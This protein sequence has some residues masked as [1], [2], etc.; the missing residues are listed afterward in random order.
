MKSLLYRFTTTAALLLGVAVFLPISAQEKGTILGI[1]Y[2]AGNGNPLPQTK[3]E[4]TGPEAL[5]LTTDTDGAYTAN[6]PAGT[7][8]IKFASEGKLPA[9]IDGLLVVAGEVADG[10]TVLVAAGEATQVEVTASIA[11]EVATAEVLLTERKLADTVQDSISGEEIK[12]GTANDAAG[13]LE[14]VTGV[15]VVND[16]YVYVR[17]LGE[18]YSSTTLNNSMLATTEPERRVVPLDLFP[19]EPDRQ[20]P[21]AEDL[22]A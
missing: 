10:S 19:A 13:A 8:N 1:V 3:V 15:S 21:G 17:G 5:S 7:Y 20:H 16:S 2:D 9:T 11:P 12:A 18:R 22:L 6:V 14:K 4:I